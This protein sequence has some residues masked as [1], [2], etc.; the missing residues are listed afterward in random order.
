MYPEGLYECIRHLSTVGVPLVVSENG[1]S[2]SKDTVRPRWIE[3]YAAQVERAIQDGYDVRGYLY[4][5]LYDNF[6]WQFGFTQRCWRV[7]AA[8]GSVADPAGRSGMAVAPW[9]P[10]GLGS[11]DGTAK[12]GT[13]SS[14]RAPRSSV[15]GYGGCR[16]RTS[17]RG[18]RAAR[19]PPRPQAGPRATPSW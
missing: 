8:Q 10:A 7:R 5:T 12:R 17:V 3:G 16:R 9:C 13:A 11:S 1:I 18:R 19:N 2:D 6:E 4:W 14:A 15:R